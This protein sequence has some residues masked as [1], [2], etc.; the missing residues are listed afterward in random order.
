M[1]A[2]SRLYV[3]HT[4]EIIPAEKDKEYPLD[5][6]YLEQM[7]AFPGLSISVTDT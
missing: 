6:K 7:Q 5:P 3:Q 2:A 4:T 1:A